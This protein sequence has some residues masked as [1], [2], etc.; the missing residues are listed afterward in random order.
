MDR[1]ANPTT[2]Q[3]KE[4]EPIEPWPVTTFVAGAPVIILS[5]KGKWRECT[6]VAVDNSPANGRCGWGGAI[7]VNYVG[8]RDDFNE[9]ISLGNLSHRVR[10]AASR[11]AARLRVGL[12][13]LSPNQRMQEHKKA[14][15]LLP[16]LSDSPAKAVNALLLCGVWRPLTDVCC[17]SEEKDQLCA[18]GIGVL[19]N[20]TVTCSVLCV[21]CS[22]VHNIKN[23]TS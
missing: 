5:P 11:A 13:E 21:A 17:C 7:Q 10:P 16:W 22:R 2:P 3:R 8:F 20:A 23:E 9:W 12:G 15:P 19:R 6:V 14:A 1:L 4:E 18:S